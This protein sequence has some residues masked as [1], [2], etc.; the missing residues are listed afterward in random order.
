MDTTAPS[1]IPSRLATNVDYLVSRMLD[2]CGDPTEITEMYV[3]AQYMLHTLGYS[4][5]RCQQ[6]VSKTGAKKL[7]KKLLDNQSA[8]YNVEGR[9]I[10]ID[11]V[12]HMTANKLQQSLDVKHIQK[13]KEKQQ[14]QPRTNVNNSDW[15]V[16]HTST[17]KNDS[18][19]YYPLLDDDVIDNEEITQLK[20]NRVTKNKKHQLAFNLKTILDRIIPVL[21]TDLLYTN[22]KVVWIR[23]HTFNANFILP[24]RVVMSNVRG[25][26]I[27]K[28]DKH[29]INIIPTVTNGGSDVHLN[30]ELVVLP[31]CENVYEVYMEH[32]PIMIAAM[33]SC[34]I[35]Y[36][37]GIGNVIFCSELKL[38]H[39]NPLLFLSNYLKFSY[40]YGMPRGIFDPV[41]FDEIR[42]MVLYMFYGLLFLKTNNLTNMPSETHGPLIAYN[43][44]RP[45]AALS[46]FDS[47][48]IYVNEG[49]RAMLAMDKASDMGS[50]SNFIEI[51]ARINLKPDDILNN[52]I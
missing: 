10:G 41:D 22:P 14:E 13:K 1:P 43:G 47:E 50:L 38:F 18:R 21:K 8:F 11:C 42:T 35:D 20:R 7:F 36:I 23:F 30:Y 27:N 39:Y 3:I 33:V 48:K 51:V 17:N 19:K 52:I 45:R 9:A 2:I 28:F 46:K 34:L 16:D 44:E 49:T 15:D 31:V 5:E 32:N 24:T 40:C 29:V 4:L 12:A 25:N 6:L 37:D 26:I